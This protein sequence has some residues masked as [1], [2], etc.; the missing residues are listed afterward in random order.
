MV[1]G[2]QCGTGAGFRVICQL[3]MP[4][5]P[6]VWTA[7]ADTI[8]GWPRELGTPLEEARA[9]EGIGRSH[10]RDGHPTQ[11]AALLRDALAI[12]Q[13]I[14]APAARRVQETLRQPGLSAASAYPAPGQEPAHQ[15]G[16]PPRSSQ[17]G[18]KQDQLPADE[19]T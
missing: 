15:R 8:L 7:G 5:V 19:A 6:A 9:L 2:E 11:A 12:Y 13:R 16:I 10:L 14:A 1:V 3:G 18:I 17:P 4:A